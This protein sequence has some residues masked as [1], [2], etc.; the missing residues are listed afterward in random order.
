MRVHSYWV[1]LI[2]LHSIQKI[3]KKVINFFNLCGW[4]GLESFESLQGERS[5]KKGWKPLF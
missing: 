5:I 3:K 4:S 1:A 2:D